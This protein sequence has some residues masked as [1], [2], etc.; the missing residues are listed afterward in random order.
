M[1][2]FHVMAVDKAGASNVRAEN[3]DQHLEWIKNHLDKVK[4]AGPML[5]ENG[6]GMIGSIL[7]IE[8]ESKDELQSFLDEDPYA[9]AHL[10]QS[11][12]ITP[13]K[14]VIGAPD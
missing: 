14:W 6:E 3:R 1:S 10:F 11:V 8:A 5:T 9:R 2:L 7:I 13:F 12:V 4:L